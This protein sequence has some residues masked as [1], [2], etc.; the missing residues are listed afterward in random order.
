M[1]QLGAII[2]K[3][4]NNLHNYA[5]FGKIFWS[6]IY[7][8]MSSICMSNDNFLRY[9]SKIWRYFQKCAQKSRFSNFAPIFLPEIGRISKNG[10]CSDDQGGRI[11]QGM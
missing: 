10:E 11:D 4:A 7:L 2:H 5:F 3:N 8:N 1:T 6:G 9:N